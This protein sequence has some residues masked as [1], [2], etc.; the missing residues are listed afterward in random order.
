MSDDE[1]HQRI[2]RAEARR[3]R[4]TLVRAQLGDEPSEPG[5]FGLEGM[6]LA[7]KLSFAAAAFAGHPVARASRASIE[8]RWIPS[9]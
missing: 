2:L 7:A 6:I 8:V 4:M 5:T 9:P 3:A 1:E